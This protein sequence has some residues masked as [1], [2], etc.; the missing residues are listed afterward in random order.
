MTEPEQRDTGRAEHLTELG[1]LSM[2]S[3]REGDVHTIR[4]FGEL[5]LAGA[6]HVQRELEQAETTDAESIVMDLSGLTFMDSTGVRLMV[7]AAARSR[8]DTNRLRLLRGP[9]AVQRVFE[10]SAVADLLPFADD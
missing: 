2:S 3:E 6:D 4:L 10:L 9:A 1:H 5:D 7:T 8:A